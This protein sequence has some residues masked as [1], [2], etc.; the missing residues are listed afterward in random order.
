MRECWSFFRDFVENQIYRAKR[1][2][3]AKNLFR[4]LN[5]LDTKY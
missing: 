4:P 2:I 5:H 1:Q 3:N